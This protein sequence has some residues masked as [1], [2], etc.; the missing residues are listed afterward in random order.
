VGGVQRKISTIKG[1]KKKR[2]KQPT[3]GEE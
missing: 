2:N 3:E 1:K